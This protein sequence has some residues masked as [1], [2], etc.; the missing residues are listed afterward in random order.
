MHKKY[1]ACDLATGDFDL[2]T[3]CLWKSLWGDKLVYVFCSKGE[4]DA[5]DWLRTSTTTKLHY[6]R[7]LFCPII[8]L[9]YKKM[10][11]Y[12]FFIFKNIIVETFL[13]GFVFL[14]K[15]WTALWFIIELF[16]KSINKQIQFFLVWFGHSFICIS[17]D[18]SNI[19]R[20]TMMLGAERYRTTIQV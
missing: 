10:Y 6:W 15:Y 3:W 9:Y 8:H 16:N 11:R 20:M 4:E 17:R 2:W 1:C 7:F 18:F 14:Q 19:E 13:L 5:T 12:L